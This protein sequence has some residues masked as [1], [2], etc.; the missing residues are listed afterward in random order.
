MGDLIVIIQKLLA[1][2]EAIISIVAHVVLI[3]SII[4]KLTP[5]LKDDNYL[6]PI[7]K[8]IGKWLALSKYGPPKSS[9]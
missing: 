3:A 9:A 6:K 2:K 1:N 5:T 4:I 7:I 8:F